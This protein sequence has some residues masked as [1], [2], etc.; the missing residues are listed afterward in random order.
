MRIQP[1]SLP[2]FLAIEPTVHRDE[3]G[4]F[5][6]TYRSSA[7]EEAGLVTDWVQD[8]HARSDRGV[9]R[10]MHY[11]V[12]PGQVKLVRCARGRVLDVVVDIRAGSPTF[13]RWDALELDDLS[14]RQA[15]V[16]LGFA[17]GYYVLSETADVV[18][19]C[20]AYYD[21]SKERGIRYDD[22]AVGIEWPEGDRIVSERDAAAPLLADLGTDLPVAFTS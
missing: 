2:G 15:Y 17:H 12:D 8:N 11:S 10:G 7:L 6:E 5:V 9:L 21:G 1:T 14:G 20:S 22:P 16:P 13:G 4:F 19:K 3:R 18:Y